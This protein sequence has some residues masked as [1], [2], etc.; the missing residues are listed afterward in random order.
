MA[1]KD[2]TPTDPPNPPA[3]PELVSV[4]AAGPLNE[5]GVHYNTG[6]LLTLTPKRVEALGNAVKPASAE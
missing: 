5:D 1:K 3:T 2:E 6:D 4:Q